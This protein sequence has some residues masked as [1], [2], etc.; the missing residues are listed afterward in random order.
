MGFLKRLL[1][2]PKHLAPTTQDWIN[3]H[4]AGQ[5]ISAGAHTYGIPHLYGVGQAS[6]TIGKFCSIADQVS[7]FIGFEHDTKS[8]STFPFTSFVKHWTHAKPQT[9]T[10]MTKG[11]LTIGHDVWIGHRATI[12]SGVTI[13]NGAVIGAGAVVTKDIAPYTIVGGVPAKPLR[14][15]FPD[16]EIAV[17]QNLQWWDWPDDL[18]Q[19]AVPLL[20]QNN[21]AALQDFAVKHGLPRSL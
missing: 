2:G 17:L 14:T 16:A 10:Q 21:I 4:H 8:I 12:L 6:L 5:N 19:Q 18:L 15:R 1:R 11:N 13:G 7:L 3:K 20:Q 9:S